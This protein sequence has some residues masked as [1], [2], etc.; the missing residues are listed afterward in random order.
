M[1]TY[2]SQTTAIYSKRVHSRFVCLTPM[3]SYLFQITVSYSRCVRS[4]FVCLT[5]LVTYLFQVTVSCSGSVCFVFVCQTQMVTYLF[6]MTV[7]F[8]K[9]LLA[10]CLSGSN[11][12]VSIPNGHQFQETFAR[13]L[14]GSNGDV[15]IS[16][17]HQFQGTSFFACSCLSQMVTYPFQ[18][19]INF[20]ERVL[21]RVVW[22]AQTANQNDG[23]LL[24]TC[25]LT[26]GLS[27][28]MVQLA[29]ANT[30]TEVTL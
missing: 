12:G 9:H 29:T 3:V 17:D 14:S 25:S 30:S 21:S 15:S 22:L 11:G 28:V 18:T 19:T 10:F 6:Q 23:Q 8:R 16:N 26:F 13:V 4:R 5:Q 1:V 24:Q 2:P 27:G 7:S 20:R